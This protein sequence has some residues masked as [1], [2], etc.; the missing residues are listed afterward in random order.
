M[1]PFQKERTEMD[2]RYQLKWS[3][4][5]VVGEQ[6]NKKDFAIIAKN[7]HYVRIKSLSFEQNSIPI[8]L[9][10]VKENCYEMCIPEELQSKQTLFERGNIL[11]FLG[12]E[13]PLLNKQAFLLHSSFIS[14]KGNG[15]LFTAPSGTGKSTQANL[16]EKYEKAEI[17]NGDRTIVRKIDDKFIGFG[18]PYA[19]SSGIYR[20]ESAHV[21]AIVVLS[22]AKKNQIQRLNGRQAF[23][24]LYKETLMNTWNST[25]M[26]QMIDLL[27]EVSEKI[28][29]YHLECRPDKEAVMLVKKA[30][31]SI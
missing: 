15:I 19:G 2:L 13:E 9:S 28:P 16:W 17:Y 3:D 23:L 5:I 29:V 24:P 31:L 20:N 6:I 11:D 30:V 8:M 7:N 10:K 26:T 4:R 1:L 22:Q 14:W 25:Y 18:S 12:L 27:K 21:K